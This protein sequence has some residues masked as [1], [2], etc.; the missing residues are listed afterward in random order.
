[1]V[2]GVG[3]AV[4]DGGPTGH[5]GEDIVA[6]EWSLSKVIGVPVGD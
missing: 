2:T 6:Q 4:G 1:M 3:V 5:V